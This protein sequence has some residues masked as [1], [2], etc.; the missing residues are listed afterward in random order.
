MARTNTIYGGLDV[1][2]ESLPVAYVSAELGAAVVFLGISG[3]R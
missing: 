1:H 3:T 2:K